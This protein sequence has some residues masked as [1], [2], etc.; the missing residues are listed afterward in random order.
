LEIK[1]FHATGWEL[2]DGHQGTTQGSD[3]SRSHTEVHPAHKP[4]AGLQLLQRFDFS[5]ESA[6]CTVVVRGCTAGGPTFTYLKGSP[7]VVRCLV[8]PS[9][10]PAN[11]DAVLDSLTQEG[12][13]C[14][15]MRTHN[16]LCK[17]VDSRT[18]IL[19]DTKSSVRCF[20]KC[21]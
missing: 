12:Y 21:C 17:R 18:K 5:S 2:R 4:S 19:I 11:F 15:H 6:R 16:L 10:L 3:D 14:A 1:L 9:S 8:E 13:R 7:E 20:F